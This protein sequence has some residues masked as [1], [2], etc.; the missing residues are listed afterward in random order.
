MFRERQ[1]R[2]S[3]LDVFPLWYS[4]TQTLTPKARLWA[5][6]IKAVLQIQFLLVLED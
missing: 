6:Q 2:S 3:L 5:T 4:R 1:D